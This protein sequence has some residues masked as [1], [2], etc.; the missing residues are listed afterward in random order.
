MFDMTRIDDRGPAIRLDSDALERLRAALDRE[1]VAAAYLFGSQASGRAGPLAD[2][3]VALWA[4]PGLDA[5]RRVALRLELTGAAASALR[6]DEVDVVLLDDAPALVRHR[7]WKSGRLLVDRD[8]V[9]RVRGEARA[10]VEYLD[11]APLR[12]QLAQGL[13]RRLAEDRFGR[14]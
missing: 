2:V 1:E 5:D 13:R 11:T 8:P 4:R 3:D 6:S 14:S 9:T 12:E 10:L 7:A